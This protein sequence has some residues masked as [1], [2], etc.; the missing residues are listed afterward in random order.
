MKHTHV[1]LLGVFACISVQANDNRPR[2]PSQLTAAWAIGSGTTRAIQLNW[3]DN[4]ANETSFYIQRKIG[5][6]TWATLAA[7]TALPPGTNSF[8]DETIPRGTSSTAVSHVY[9]RLRAKNGTIESG[10]AEV[11]T[12]GIPFAWPTTNY[13]QDA[14]G[15]PENLESTYGGTDNDW[16]N[17][18]GDTNG[19]SIPNAWE[20]NGVTSLAFNTAVTVDATRTLPDT[21]TETKTIGAA[22]SKLSGTHNKNY[23]VILVKPGIYNENINNASTYNIAFVADKSMGNKY[24]ACEV[25]GSGTTPV[26]STIGSSVFI[27]FVVS[28]TA[29]TRGAAFSY[30]ESA[31]PGARVSICGLINCLFSGMDTDVSPL[32]MQNR[33]RLSIVHTTFYNNS[34]SAN[35]KAH[36]YSSGEWAVT[37]TAPLESTAQVSITNS[38]L[39]NPIRV[40]IP[41]CFSVGQI[42]L[43]GSI[44]YNS[45]H[46]TEPVAGT[47]H[48]NPNLT[49]AGYLLTAYS[50]ANYGGVE[51][52]GISYDIHGETHSLNVNSQTL[53]GRG[54]DAWSD[55]DAD[56]I[57]DFAD[58]NI[59]SPLNA[60]QDLDFDLLSEL[61]EYQDGTDPDSADSAYLTYDQAQ[62][63][64][65]PASSSNYLTRTEAD[66]RYIQR[67]GALQRV[68]VLPGGN[69][70]MGSFSGG[71][72]PAP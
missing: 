67:D 53:R 1:I 21:S 48:V 69:I 23:R 72:N 52:T 18:F 66:A 3:Q 68:R 12:I 15:I 25:R 26:I 17:A 36:T 6:G 70:P 32:V 29:G 58:S 65:M 62:R 47:A 7:A 20:A 55:I 13:D 49:P 34:V 39:W 28:R 2:P 38:I 44:M 45:K 60:Q 35:A 54:A 19:N 43:D 30:S 31:T 63:L 71:S 27:G 41:E 50:A 14:D 24:T 16:S 8:S 11:A 57:P 33:G 40:S 9:Y 59:H 46:A 37:A 51:N 42:Q 61:A 10:A 64:F 4:S 56:G 5:A 22:I